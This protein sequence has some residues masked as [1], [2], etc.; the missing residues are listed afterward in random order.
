MSNNTEP[1]AVDDDAQERIKKK[2]KQL[3][4]A[5]QAKAKKKGIKT[6]YLKRIA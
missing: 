5:L 2:K 6:K 1:G 4:E 3:Q